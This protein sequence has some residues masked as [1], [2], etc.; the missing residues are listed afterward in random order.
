MR[1]SWANV[2]HT[3]NGS[4]PARSHDICMADPGRAEIFALPVLGYTPSPAFS[5]LS[6]VIC[7]LSFHGA[8]PARRRGPA[9]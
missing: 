1:G 4:N 5:H 9:P 2:F 3:P 6:F 8:E 7:H